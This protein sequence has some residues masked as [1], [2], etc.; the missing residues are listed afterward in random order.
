MSNAYQDN[1]EAIFG[2]GKKVDRGS[3]VWDE[4]KNKLVP[5]DEYFSAYVGDEYPD[6]IKP[7][8]PFT[9]PIDGTVISCRSTLRKH[10]REHGV[11]NV[12]DYGE[13]YFE[14][15]G[16]EK[17]NEMTGN[18]KEAKHERIETIKAAMRKH[19]AQ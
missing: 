15:R 4:V 6:F 13:T 1:F 9:S 8:D 5:R 10:N 17:Y 11:T 2:K 16:K 3:W 19:G 7:L 12:A 18:T 14:R